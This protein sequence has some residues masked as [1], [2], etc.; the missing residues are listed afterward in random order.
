MPKNQFVDPNEV[1][2]KGKLTFSDIEINSYS[3]TIDEE[4]QLFTKEEFLRIYRDMKIIREFETMLY[5]V[6]TFGEHDGYCVGGS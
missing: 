6:K 3:K 1:R 2:S 4:K 5:N